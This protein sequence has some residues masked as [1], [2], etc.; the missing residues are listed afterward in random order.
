[1]P[2]QCAKCGGEMAAGFVLDKGY[3][4]AEVT[5]WQEGEPQK[6]FWHG[7]TKQAGKAEYEITTWRCT[8]CGYLESYAG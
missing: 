4:T 6:S 3:G 2:A 7:L 5:A 1:M 8:C